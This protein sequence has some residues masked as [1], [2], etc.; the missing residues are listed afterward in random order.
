VKK[1]FL[2]I[3]ILILLLGCSDPKTV[4]D[5]DMTYRIAEASFNF[6]YSACEANT[7]REEARKELRRIF[8]PINK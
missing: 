1:L 7:P 3:A 5:V 4:E 2:A 6:G 8:Y